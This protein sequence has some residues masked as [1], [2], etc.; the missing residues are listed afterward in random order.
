MKTFFQL[1]AIA[2]VVA[3]GLVACSG[4]SRSGGE[5]LQDSHPQTQADS[6]SYFFGGMYADNFWRSNSYDSIALSEGGRRKYLEGVEKGLGFDDDLRFLE[7]ISAGIQIRL[8]IN[9]LE[10]DLGVHLSKEQILNALAYG[11]RSDTS[12]N[13]SENQKSLRQIVEA[14]GKNK[15]RADRAAAEVA[16]EKAGEKAG[17]KLL[18]EGVYGKI[19]GEPSG[20][21]LKEGDLVRVRMQFQTLNGKKLNLPTPE[22]IQIGMM[23]QETLLEPVIVKLSSREKMELITSAVG[24][25][26]SQCSR[27]DLK[28]TDIV[29]VTIETLGLVDEIG[30]GSK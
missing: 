20:E 6:L 22:V 2:A 9:D 21:M 23:F 24:V 11:L 7:G 5:S 26:G 18:S 29:K 12:L 3:L 27:M 13:W 15:D 14:I 10:K 8:A 4:S 28:P 19:I 25:F 1:A 30:F 16:V 17:M